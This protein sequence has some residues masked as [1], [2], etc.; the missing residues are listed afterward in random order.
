M[1]SLLLNHKSQASYISFL[2]F[3]PVFFLIFSSANFF[4]IEFKSEDSFTLAMKQFTQTSPQSTPPAFQTPQPIEEVLQEP[5]IPP[6]IVKKMKK[7]G[8]RK[9]K[10]RAKNPPLQEPM[11]VIKEPMQTNP[12][13]TPAKSA[14]TQAVTRLVQGKDEHPFLKEI[15]RA[16]KEA[17][18]YPRQARKMRMQGVV[19][20]E[21][22]WR[23]NKTLADLNI[24]ESSGH[25]LLDNSALES[26]RKAALHFPHYPNDLRIVLPIAY[27]LN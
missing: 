9:D 10:I 12:T 8:E 5:Q 22:L 27:N 1:K 7:K 21:F 2:A 19:R 3:L 20:V 23:E 24:I 16:I 26:I 4:K 17:Q 25:H 13:L 15:A 14:N 11:Q 6:K 18:I